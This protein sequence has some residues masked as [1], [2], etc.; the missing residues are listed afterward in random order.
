M[1][2]WVDQHCG[3]LLSPYPSYHKGLINNVLMN[4]ILTTGTW[5]LELKKLS[6]I[7]A[8]HFVSCV[9]DPFFLFEKQGF[10]LVN[11]SFGLL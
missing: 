8:L 7:S 1:N 5:A 10:V 2:P 6:K 4:W 3:L 11:Q 9:P